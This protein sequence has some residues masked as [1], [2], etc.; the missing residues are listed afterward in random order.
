VNLHFI[1]ARSAES[2]EQR[3]TS[4]DPDVVRATNATVELLAMIRRRAGV[5]VA[6]FS[7][8]AE[9]YFSFWS[10]SEVCRRAG[11]L[12]IPGVG[13]AVEAAEAAGQRVTG[14]PVDSHWNGRGHA[15]AAAVIDDWLR[16]EGLVPQP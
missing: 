15:I 16:R 7:V 10:R 1:R 3:L 14:A 8:R 12:F 13:E 4:D 2:A 5:P 9:D 6:A 11:V